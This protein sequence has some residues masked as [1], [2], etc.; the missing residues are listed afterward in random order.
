MLV[1]LRDEHAR[2][3]PA[4]LV[5]VESA[6]IER[7]IN[8]FHGEQTSLLVVEDAD[9]PSLRERF[10]SPITTERCIGWLHL[11]RE[12]LARYATRVARLLDRNAEEQAALVLLGPREQ[13][14]LELVGEL[15]NSAVALELSTLRWTA[16]RIR[17][18]PLTQA[19]RVG[20]AAVLYTGHGNAGGWLAYG[21]LTASMLAGDEHW[22]SDETNAMMIS[23]SCS[24]GR[25]RSSTRAGVSR[26]GFADE[27]V[28]RG[29]AGAVL[30]PL[31]DP[32]HSHSR[33]VA[34]AV[35]RAI[36]ESDGLVCDIL[37]HVVRHGVSLDGYA[38]V[39]DPALP[40]RSS[41]GAA[42]RAAAVFAPA[43]DATLTVSAAW[44]ERRFD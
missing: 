13:R 19:L 38:V 20:A 15:E 43:A 26:R 22:A 1:P 36:A 40:V 6:R 25:R 24:T 7:F 5:P 34:Q 9:C 44:G 23:L 31:T 37:E 2:F 14:Y 39:G 27:V 28:E 17:R 16:E 21:G 41:L 42:A 12:E 4:D 29:V 35:V 33:L 18:A 3:G 8:E 30:A 10:P 11:N 32:L